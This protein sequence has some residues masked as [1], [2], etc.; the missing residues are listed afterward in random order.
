M[1]SSA[2]FEDDEERSNL[3]SIKFATKKSIK[4]NKRDRLKNSWRE[5]TVKMK[6][7][8][9]ASISKKLSNADRMKLCFLQEMTI[10]CISSAANR[11]NSKK[12]FWPS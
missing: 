4:S 6:S 10:V 2:E 9:T 3:C 11:E 7:K 12:W 5:L 1:N 8:L